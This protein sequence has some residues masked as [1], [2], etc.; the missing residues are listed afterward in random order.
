MIDNHIL[1]KAL[2]NKDKRIKTTY[3]LDPELKKLIEVE[4]KNKGVNSSDILNYIIMERY[5]GG[6]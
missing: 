6:C 1:L 5:K 3:N 2:T 4:A